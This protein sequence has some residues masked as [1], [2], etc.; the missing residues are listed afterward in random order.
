MR[1]LRLV[2]VAAIA[3]LVLGTIAHAG[4]HEFVASTTGTLKA[5]K[6]K[7]IFT[8]G[9]A[10]VTC[11]QLSV[12]GSVATAKEQTQNVTVLP[13]KCEGFGSAKVTVSE[14]E[15]LFE[16]SLGASEIGPIVVLT[17]AVGKC[18]I[19]IEGAGAEGTSKGGEGTLK[20]TN[21]GKEIKTTQLVTEIEY[22]SSGGVCGEP[23]M[24]YTNGTIEA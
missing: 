2:G 1:D 17:N 12:K 6:G 15:F 23:E 13:S 9:S 22:E 8:F 11:T 5:T 14:A 4:A 18:S 21:T 20:Y 16:A 7:E 10:K 24:A 19:K 3:L